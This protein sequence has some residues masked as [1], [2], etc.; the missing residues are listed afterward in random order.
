MTRARQIIL[1]AVLATLGA[2]LPTSADAATGSWSLQPASWDFGSRSPTEGQSEPVSFTLTNTGD[3]SLHPAFVAVNSDGDF[4]L[5]RNE[6]EFAIPPGGD[7]EVEVTFDPEGVGHLEGT[8]EI[9][10]RDG[11]APP[12]IAALTGTGKGS[13]LTIDPPRV[14][15]GTV[16][17]DPM[18]F[19]STPPP[20][21]TVTITNQGPLTFY[22][23]EPEIREISESAEP[24][25]FAPLEW[26]GGTCNPVRREAPL[27]PGGS[28]TETF[29]FDPRE[30]GP[31][32]AELLIM[33]DALESPQ[34]LEIVGTGAV[35]VVG[36]TA[37]P[38]SPEAPRARIRTGPGKRT[39]S[40]WAT[41]T[42]GGTP[43]ATSFQCRLDKGHYRPC[44]SPARFR[45][46]KPG[47]HRFSILPID[48]KTSPPLQGA[49]VGYSW[50]ILD[51][52]RTHKAAPHKHYRGS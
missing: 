51:D 44:T 11:E 32:S 27:L 39:E 6:C 19:R 37:F 30:P 4:R 45:S 14:D 21:Q 13:T 41:F 17:F 10:D 43:N 40:R 20:T 34:R 52:G 42:F 24:G 18:V 48:S 9:F 22:R 49:P 29:A 25:H 31:D 8:L 2:V 26:T 16:E 23:F 1:V 35:A 28:C 38:P 46:L 5:H 12:A 36:P 3:V 50:R 7:C 33:G 15:F 47:K